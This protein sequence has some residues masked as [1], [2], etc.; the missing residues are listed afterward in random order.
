MKFLLTGGNGYVGSHVANSL[1]KRGHD[2]VVACRSLDRKLPGVEYLQMDVLSG[3]SDI[4]LRSGKPDAL[5]HLAWDDG[6]NHNST[7][8][9]EK[10]PLHINFLRNMLEK[11]LKQI[12][13]IGTM[14]E[15]GYYVGIVDENTPTFPYHAYGIAK[16]H[17]REVQKLLCH[18]YNALNQWTRCFYI[19]GE[20]SRNKSIFA[21]LL[22]AENAGKA[23]FSLNSGELLYDFISV[24]EL[25]D[26]IAAVASQSE[27]TGIINCCSGR[28]IS[29][30]TMV[31]RFI[32]E[33]NLKI[34]PV[35]GQF[36]LRPYDSQAIWGDT[37]KLS[38][39]LKKV[40]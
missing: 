19:Y 10:L 1:I 12:T 27:I 23:E 30:K 21:K 38:D 36:P 2:V 25:G 34:K 5:I 33:N 15:V 8:H 6:F 13:G 35:W 18:E 20:D 4:Y 32:E 9:L 31:L 28:P 11:G 14:H 26:M 3:D 40:I 22:E 29:L 37:T 16:N 7:I 39:I 24:N 17:L